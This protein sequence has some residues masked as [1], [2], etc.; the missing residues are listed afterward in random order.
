M[1]LETV[2]AGNSINNL[3]KLVYSFAEFGRN[4]LFVGEPGSGKEV[5]SD[6]YAEG[7][8]REKYPLNCVGLT[9]STATSALFGHKK[10]SFTGA[11]EDRDGL[12]KKANKGGMVFL[13]ELGAASP[14][15]KAQLLR[16]LETGDYLPLG[17]DK[18]EKIDDVSVCAAT[19]EPEKI[20]QD[21]RDRF[22]TLYIPPLRC[23]EGDIPEIIKKILKDEDK[24]PKYISNNVLN[25]LK[26]HSWPDNIRGLQ[27]VLQIA[28]DL[29][30]LDGSKI[31]R[32]YHLPLL[33]NSTTDKSKRIEIS[34]LAGRAEV[35]PRNSFF[36][37][38]H[39]IEDVNKFWTDPESYKKAFYNYFHSQGLTASKLH[40]LFPDA[41][42][43]TLKAGIGRTKEG[44]NLS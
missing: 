44:Y 4:L 12:F 2:A 39:S 34:T 11:L 30:N 18:T 24:T 17:S 36:K 29:A 40:K 14:S 13:D 33:S 35:I 21:L 5:F 15:F 8:K 10:G 1:K 25:S 3:K 28:V 16:V 27:K 20:R 26:N 22:I 23:R 38:F 32:S 37:P 19:S 42:I 41:A 7:C 9:D 31:I 43:S 6:I